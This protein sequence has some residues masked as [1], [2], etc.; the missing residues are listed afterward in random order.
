M[1]AN[2]GDGSHGHS[3]ERKTHGPKTS[4]HEQRGMGAE[5]VAIPHAFSLGVMPC[6]L[7]R[8]L[9]W[10]SK[11]V[12]VLLG[13][14]HEAVGTEVVKHALSRVSIHYLKTSFIFSSCSISLK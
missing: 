4:Q 7:K 8:L 12:H 6:P 9:N 13:H 10:L 2:P 3:Y 11:L 14:W 1:V 5:E